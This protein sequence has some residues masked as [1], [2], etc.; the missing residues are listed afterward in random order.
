MKRSSDPRATYLIAALGLV[1]LLEPL[2]IAQRS[3]IETGAWGGDHIALEV[4]RAGARVEFDCAHGTLDQPL[5]PDRR[6]TFDVKGTFTSEAGGPTRRNP[7]TQ[8]RAAQ[9]SGH[10]SGSTLTLTVV[11]AGTKESI[12]TFTL[13]RGQPRIT[14]CQ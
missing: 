12:G 1:A 7:S 8:S 6:G 11:L 5:R 2:A 9:Y 3:R 10:I 14:K 13:T 4:T